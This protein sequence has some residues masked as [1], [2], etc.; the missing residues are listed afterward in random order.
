M[1]ASVC[2]CVCTVCFFCVCGCVHTGAVYACELLAE[3]EV[4]GQLEHLWG[5]E[6]GEEDIEICIL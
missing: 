6:G 2:D 4:G 1:R 5:G 3:V